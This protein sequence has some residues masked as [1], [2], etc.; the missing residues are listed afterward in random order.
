[1]LYIEDEGGVRLFEIIGTE[2]TEVEQA[3]KVILKEY[4]NVVSQ[5]AHDIENCWIIKHTIRLLDKTPV[6]GKQGHWSPREHKW[7][8]E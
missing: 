8:E 3:L 5:E 4:D 6:V 1:M 7:I 2:E